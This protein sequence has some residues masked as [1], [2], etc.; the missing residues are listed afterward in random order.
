[1]KPVKEEWQGMDWSQRGKQETDYIGLHRSLDFVL[2]MVGSVGDF[3]FLNGAGDQTRYLVH[4]KARAS[5]TSYT[6]SPAVNTQ[7]FE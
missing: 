2:N 4:A 7:D 6:L 3:F 1:V 5:T